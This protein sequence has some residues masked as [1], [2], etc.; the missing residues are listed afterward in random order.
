MGWARRGAAAAA[1]AL[2]LGGCGLVGDA[3]AGITLAAGGSGDGAYTLSARGTPLELL[4]LRPG[5]DTVVEV[6]DDADDLDDAVPFHLV[7]QGEDITLVTGP[8]PEDAERI[9]VRSGVTELDGNVVD[10]G[11]DRVFVVRLVGHRTIDSITALDAEGAPLHI[12]AP[13]SLE[14]RA[15]AT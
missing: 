4:L 9:V 14:P 7:D 12:T 1:V 6:G 5:G 8:V 13:R 2:V 10:V 15:P 3:D 11:E